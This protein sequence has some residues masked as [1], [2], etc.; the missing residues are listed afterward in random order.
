[1]LWGGGT[2]WHR[3]CV[4]ASGH[5][6]AQPTCSSPPIGTIGCAGTFITLTLYVE[7]SK[8]DGL[9]F[10]LFLSALTALCLPSTDAVTTT[11]IC[12]A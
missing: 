2:D 7:L 10:C 4:A 3:L 9:A 5:R 1:M 12:G 8:S 6:H 11:D